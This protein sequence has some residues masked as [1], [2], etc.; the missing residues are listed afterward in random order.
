MAITT[1]NP[2]TLTS[3]FS[4]FLAYLYIISG[5][6]FYLGSIINPILYNVV[7]NKYRRAFLDLFCCRIRNKTKLNK[8]NRVEKQ[9]MYYFMKKK[10]QNQDTNDL[11]TVKLSPNHHQQTIDRK[12]VV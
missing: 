12:S 10:Q 6:T 7:S 2:K 9:P 8:T 4:N 3:G 5:I 1:L 11:K